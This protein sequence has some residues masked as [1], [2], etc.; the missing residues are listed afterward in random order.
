MKEEIKPYK[1]I[2]SQIDI[3]EEYYNSEYENAIN[4]KKLAEQKA[5]KLIEITKQLNEQEKQSSINKNIAIQ[6]AQGE[7]EALK[8]KG[9][10]I[11]ANPKIVQLEWI[12]KW[13]GKLP[14]Y[15]LGSGSNTL[16]GIGNIK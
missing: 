6:K 8:I 2:L 16:I 7:A 1:L 11:N 14:D 3:R 12:N 13:N 15:M 10:A 4:E 5:L 9:Q